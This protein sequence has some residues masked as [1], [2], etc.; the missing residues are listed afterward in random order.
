[1]RVVHHTISIGCPVE[2]NGREGRLVVAEFY[3]GLL[4]MRII[5]VNWLK[6]GKHPAALPQ[7]AFSGDGWSDTRPPRWPDPEYPQQ[8]HLDL[9]VRDLADAEAR[10][11]G[12]G[13]VRLAAYADH[14]VYADPVGHPF[15]L[16]PAEVDGED[17]VIWRVIFD[18]PSPPTLARFYENLVDEWERLEDSTDQVVLS[19]LSGDLPILAFQR[20]EVRSPQWP[21]PDYPAQL[22]LDLSFDDENAIELARELGALH[23]KGEVHADPAGHPFCLGIWRAAAPSGIDVHY[24]RRG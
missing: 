4:G 21:D 12:L 7:L 17:A 9:H 23:L 22:H 14:R 15:C 16:Y 24:S 1:M 3:A 6:I 13:G 18:C 2:L 11:L 20:A 5:R 19:P 8:V 10:V